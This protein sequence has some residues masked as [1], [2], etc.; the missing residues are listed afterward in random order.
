LARRVFVALFLGGRT[1]SVRPRVKRH[2]SS[3]SAPV[4]LAAHLAVLSSINFC[5]P[6]ERIV[7]R[8]LAPST[9]GLVTAGGYVM[10]QT[11][12]AGWQAALITVAATGLMLS[13]RINPPWTLATGGALGVLG[14]L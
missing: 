7:R 10:A 14:V 11:A 5:A 4:A 1:G 3:P 9:I 12:D 13:T 2:T 6:W 8:G